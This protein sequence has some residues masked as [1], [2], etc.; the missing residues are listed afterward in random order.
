MRYFYIALLTLSIVGCTDPVGFTTRQN[1]QDTAEI[2]K[3]RIAANAQIEVA[4][5]AAKAEEYKATQS[6]VRTGIIAAVAPWL[7]LIVGAS[8]VVCIMVNWQGRIAYSRSNGPRLPV[9]ELHR[10]ASE[11]GYTLV[12]E[13]DQLL[14]VDKTGHIVSR[15]SIDA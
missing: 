1:M 4:K 13:K 8:V 15:R 3:A 2:E 12:E 5:A 11:Q 14:L 10:L 9:T 7:L 6:T